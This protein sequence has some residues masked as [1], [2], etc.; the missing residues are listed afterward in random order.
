M[1]DGLRGTIG[2]YGEYIPAADLAKFTD[3]SNKVHD[4]I[5]AVRG[6][7]YTV[8]QGFELYPTSGAWSD[9]AYSRF[10]RPGEDT[11]VWALVLYWNSNRGDRGSQYGFQPPYS[12]ALEVSKE[13][14]SG[15]IQFMTSCLCVVR[16]IGRTFVATPDVLNG[17]RNFRDT[18]MMKSVRGRA[19][20]D[21]LEHHGEEVLVLL[22]KDLTAWSAS[23]KI[24]VAAAAIVLG[25]ESASPP[26]S[27]VPRRAD[28]A[29]HHATGEAGEPSAEKDPSRGAPR[30]SQASRKDGPTGSPLSG[31]VLPAS[32][33]AANEELE[34][35]CEPTMAVGAPTIGAPTLGNVLRSHLAGVSTSQLENRSGETGRCLSET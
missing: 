35:E 34:G 2:G 14:Q 9:Y 18:E 19:W 15:L 10:F 23:G 12:D 3:L 7:S 29:S 22:R 1:W 25:R 4:A 5:A 28:R 17:V 30:S 26:I 33:P 24:F 31:T 21:L 16:E 8:E 11:K 6:R 13:I 20:V 32:D 27:S